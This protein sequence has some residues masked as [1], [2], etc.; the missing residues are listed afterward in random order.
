[1]V[2]GATCDVEDEL[3]DTYLA[4][5][6][7]FFDSLAQGSSA[8]VV[9]LWL[10]GPLSFGV[11]R[12]VG[13]HGSQYFWAGGYRHLASRTN[14]RLL[15]FESALTSRNLDF[16]RAQSRKYHSILLLQRDTVQKSSWDHWWYERKICKVATQYFDQCDRI[17][18]AVAKN[19]EDINYNLI[20][21]DWFVAKGWLFPL[22][23]VDSPVPLVL[24]SSESP[25]TYQFTDSEPSD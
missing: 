4:R 10:T 13:S 20:A 11:F 7:E 17:E 21:F 16:A 15:E 5:F 14:R 8:D 6:L 23:P 1:M 3:R 24:S 12:A 22:L 2:T 9:D 18:R 19:L 25:E